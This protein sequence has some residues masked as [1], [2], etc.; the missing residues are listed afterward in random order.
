MGQRKQ[1][2]RQSCVEGSEMLEQEELSVQHFVCYTIYSELNSRASDGSYNTQRLSICLSP[3][4][5]VCEVFTAT[6]TATD[7]SMALV[8]SFPAAEEDLRVKARGGC[9]LTTGEMP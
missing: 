5:Y 4:I 7:R 3:W 8:E 9:E 1:W 6:A 2:A